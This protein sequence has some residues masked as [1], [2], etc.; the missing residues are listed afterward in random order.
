MDFS[1]LLHSLAQD[2]PLAIFVA[3][4]AVAA[5]ILFFVFLRSLFAQ[6]VESESLLSDN[7][8]DREEF[9]IQLKEVSEVAEKLLA[10]IRH[11]VA[12]KE[13]LL[14]LEHKK[15]FFIRLQ[16]NIDVLLIGFVLGIS[17][18]ATVVYFFVL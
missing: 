6:K 12:H 1:D 14:L 18:V 8:A 15:S 3:V 10:E 11:E 13:N 17:V 7:I 5:L 16:N 2:K 9:I 4:N